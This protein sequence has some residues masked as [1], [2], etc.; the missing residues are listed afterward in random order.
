MTLHSQPARHVLWALLGAALL[1]ASG[2]HRTAPVDRGG[3]ARPVVLAAR[4]GRGRVAREYAFQ[5]E[6]RPWFSVDLQARVAGYVRRLSVDLGDRVNSGQLLAE[7]DVPL[8]REDLLRAGALVSRSEGELARAGALYDEARLVSGRLSGVAAA[9]PRLLAGQEVDS[10]VAREKAAAASLA[11]ARSQLEVSKAELKRLEAMNADT[12]I[13]APFEGVIARLDASPGDFVQGG[14]APSGQAH[15]LLRLVREDRLRCAFAVS[16]GQLEALHPG[17]PVS[18]R[19]EQRLITTRVARISGEVTTAGRAMMVEADV[20]N[21]DGS[22]VPGAYATVMLT[23]QERTNA[24]YVPIEAI[25]RSAAGASVLRVD[26]AGLVSTR[27]VRIGIE[28]PARIEVLEGLEEGEVVVT[29]GAGRI[30]AGQPVEPQFAAA[31]GT[32]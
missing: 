21:A 11:A 1:A 23:G 26:A 16:V 25:Q 3:G 14:P 12:R 6:L 24:L 20:P 2:C 4:V 32:P 13:C 27:P 8:L 18:I 17:S 5:A 22:L 19:A 7:L 9:Q 30:R 31:V 28:T 15:P 10:A 29:A